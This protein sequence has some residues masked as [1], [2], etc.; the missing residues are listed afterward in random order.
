MLAPIKL[1]SATRSQVRV[2]MD[3]GRLAAGSEIAATVL[4][5]TVDSGSSPTTIIRPGNVLAK[6]STGKYTEANDSQVTESAKASVTGTVTDASSAAGFSKTFKWKYRD[7]EEQTVTMGSTTAEY[8]DNSE[9]IAALNADADFSADLLAAASGNFVVITSK[10]GG[11]LEY[12]K[13]T[14]GTLNAV[15]G[16]VDNTE[17]AGSDG[18]Y[19]VVTDYADMLDGAGVAADQHGVTCVRRGH[20]DESNLINLTKD[21]RRVLTQRGSIFES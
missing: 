3:G 18:D 21:A 16:F 14:D 4:S 7:G 19:V 13:I 5:T 11:S 8:D 12:F 9:I 6:I 10:R 17:H 20:F 2:F 1:V 15:L